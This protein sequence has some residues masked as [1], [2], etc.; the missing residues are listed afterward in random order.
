MCVYCDVFKS[1]H[2]PVS[3]KYHDL[4]ADWGLHVWVFAKFV[5]ISRLVCCRSRSVEEVVYSTVERG[6][7][8]PDVIQ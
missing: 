4:F 3:I 2:N 1:V 6:G 7:Q 8:H 5:Y